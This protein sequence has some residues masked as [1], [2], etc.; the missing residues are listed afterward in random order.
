MNASR[1]GLP[2][3]LAARVKTILERARET[4]DRASE[5]QEMLD[6]FLSA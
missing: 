2:A 4:P 3:P 5:V 1:A 6:A